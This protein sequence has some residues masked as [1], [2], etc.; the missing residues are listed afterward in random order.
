MTRIPTEPRGVKI[1]GDLRG[2]VQQFLERMGH[3]LVAG[4]GATVATF[5]GVPAIVISDHGVVAVSSLEQIS[6]F[7]SGAKQQ[8]VEQ[9]IASTRPDLVDLERIGERLV[10]AT[11]R[12]PYLDASGRERGGAERSD[13]TLR[14]NDRGELEVRCV[15]MRGVEPPPER[16]RA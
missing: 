12:W 7:F 15:L 13:Y 1:A 8:Y 11:V 10:I 3:A 16:R 6:A 9:G 14:R 4:D 5:W 2:E